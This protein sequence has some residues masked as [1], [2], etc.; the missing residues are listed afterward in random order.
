MCFSM[1][2][3][4]TSVLTIIAYSGQQDDGVYVCATENIAGR[5]SALVVLS[6]SKHMSCTV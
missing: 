3:D 4:F 5:D 6:S 1:R 2:D